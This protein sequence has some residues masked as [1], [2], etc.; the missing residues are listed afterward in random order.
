MSARNLPLQEGPQGPRFCSACGG[1]L[2]SRDPRTSGWK[3]TACGE[4]SFLDP[5]V[6]ACGVPWWNGKIVLVRRA[7]EPRRGFWASPGGYVERGEAPWRAAAREV[8]EEVGLTVATG[9]LLGAY[10]TPGS[11]VLVLYYDC[12]ILAGGPPRPLSE[13]SE[14]GLFAPEEIPWPDLAFP[15]VNEGLVAAIAHRGRAS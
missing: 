1:A 4:W 2:G 10:Q 7:I 6:A 3:C 11:P 9:K 12:E 15:S 5:K 13:C 8:M 14:V